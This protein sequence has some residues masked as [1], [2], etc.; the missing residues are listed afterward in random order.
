MFTLFA[1]CKIENSY[2]EAVWSSN[3]VIY[4]RVSDGNSKILISESGNLK[5]SKKQNAH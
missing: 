5:T 2:R 4:F 3:I 1:N